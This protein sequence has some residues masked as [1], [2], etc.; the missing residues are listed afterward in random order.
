MKV[1]VVEDDASLREGLGEVLSELADVRTAGS[2]DS[3]LVTLRQERFEL[4]IADLRIAGTA[5]GGRTILEAAR[6]RQQP[7]A[8]VS[9][10]AEEEVRKALEPFQADV[11]LSK[12]FQLEEMM[13]LVERFLGLRREV[14]RLSKERPPESGWAEAATG[15][16]VLTVSRG[17]PEQAMSWVRLQP[18]A[19]Y[20]WAHLRARSGAL[21]VQGDLELEGERSQSPHYFFL[22]TGQSPVARSQQGGLVF[23]LP[24]GG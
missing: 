8:I 10:A 3:A 15:V 6:Q 2:V 5:R 12:P 7:V 22:S 19:S 11:I 18:G 17:Q 16:Q 4:V 23:L 14:E 13:A 20:S 21:L 9:A 1:L 24:L